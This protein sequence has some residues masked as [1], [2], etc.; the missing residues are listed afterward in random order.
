MPQTGRPQTVALRRPCGTRGNRGFRGPFGPGRR[1]PLAW[2]AARARQRCAGRSTSSPRPGAVV[3]EE[4]THE[5]YVPTEQPQA[6][7]ASRVPSP[8]VDP[9]RPGH[10]FRP[11]PQG[12]PTPFGLTGRFGHLVVWSIRDRATFSALR[13]SGRRVRRG[14]VTVTWV[15]GDP[16]QPPRVAFAVGRRAGGAVVRN[17]IRRRLR[18]IVREVEPPLRPGAYLVGVSGEAASLSY[19]ELKAK[20]CQ[21]LGALERR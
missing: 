4:L 9:G 21:A 1:R 7:Q 18:S 12:P 3:E 2:F 13:Q 14:P 10:P 11:P 15:C 20:V 17:R 8:H 6:G 5:A 16:D 19:G